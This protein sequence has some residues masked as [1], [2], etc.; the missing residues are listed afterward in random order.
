MSSSEDRIGL[1]SGWF[2]T[3][4][5]YSVSM[6]MTFGMAMRPLEAVLL[7]VVKK[8]PRGVSGAGGNWGGRAPAP[9]FLIPYRYCP[10]L[11]IR[12]TLRCFSFVSPISG[13]T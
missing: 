6:P 1:K 2:L 10:V 9:R 5:P 8:N 4:I 13:L 3:V 12:S 7:T 11:T